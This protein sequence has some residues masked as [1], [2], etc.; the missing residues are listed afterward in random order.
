MNNLTKIHSEIHNVLEEK[1]VLGVVSLDL[2]KAYDDTTW[3]NR[4]T[5]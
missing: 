4:I 3:R 1:Q 5:E 2:E